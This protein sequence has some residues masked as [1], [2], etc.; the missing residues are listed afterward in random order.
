MYCSPITGPKLLPVSI[1]TEST[2]FFPYWCLKNTIRAPKILSLAFRALTKNSSPQMFREDELA[3]NSQFVV[4][5][6]GKG[7]GLSM[8][9]DLGGRNP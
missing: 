8:E 9:G 3:G 6:Y 1:K 7:F 2:A 4:R 5:S